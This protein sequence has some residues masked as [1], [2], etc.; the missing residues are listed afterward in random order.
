MCDYNHMWD[1]QYIKLSYQIGTKE[2]CFWGAF[3]SPSSLVLA[4]D[5]SM[6]PPRFIIEVSGKNA[7]RNSNLR[8][9]FGGSIKV[10]QTEIPLEVQG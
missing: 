1:K 8:L 4:C 3:K 10:L 9:D 5:E 7:T 6:Y 2:V